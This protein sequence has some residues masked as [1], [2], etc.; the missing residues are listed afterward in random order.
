M[1]FF[2]QLEKSRLKLF[3]ENIFL[4]IKS[5]CVSIG[6]NINNVLQKFLHVDNKIQYFY[7]K[8]LLNMLK[9]LYIIVLFI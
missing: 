8:T 6:K 5:F 1:S 7:T 9:T 4:W 2:H 3:V